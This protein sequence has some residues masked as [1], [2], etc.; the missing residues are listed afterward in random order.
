MK[1]DEVPI[2]ACLKRSKSCE[3]LQFGGKTKL[4]KKYDELPLPYTRKHVKDEI[5]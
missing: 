1:K 5:E 3:N 2:Y 4:E